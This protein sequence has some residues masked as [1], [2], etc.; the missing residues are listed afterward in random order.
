LPYVADDPRPAVPL[1]QAELNE[2]LALQRERSELAENLVV[3]LERERLRGHGLD[4]LAEAVRRES[5][6]DV[7]AGY[8]VQSFE[9]DGGPRLI[10]VKS[11]AGPRERFFLSEN[12]F[13]TAKANGSRYWLAW[14]S[15]AAYL[16][17]GPVDVNWYCDLAGILDGTP[18][19]WEVAP[20]SRVVRVVAD[21]GSLS[22][23]P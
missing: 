23:S 21:D 6:E 18:A 8:D 4:Y 2:R 15:W 16:P 22:C 11:S 5:I 14:V 9:V 3:R 1:S 12:E 10:E 13:E 7:C 19:A 17:E 20:A